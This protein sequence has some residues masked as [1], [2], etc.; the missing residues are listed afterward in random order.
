MGACRPAAH[1][2][3]PRAC[4][5]SLAWLGAR[6]PRSR[7]SKGQPPTRVSRNRCC[8]QRRQA[9]GRLIVLLR[10]CILEGSLAANT[11]L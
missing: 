3:C 9:Y 7:P 11:A 6:K 8:F 2:T 5:S 4:S 1:P 10:F